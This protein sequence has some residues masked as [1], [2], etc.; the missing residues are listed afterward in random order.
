MHTLTITTLT[1][2]ELF[3][4]TQEKEDKAAFA[5]LYNRY[6]N[7]LWQ[8]TQRHQISANDAQDVLQD[9]FTY[10]WVNKGQ[11]KIKHRFSSFLFRATLNQVLKKIDR[12]KFI[13]TYAASLTNKL[14]EQGIRTEDI[15]FEKE[16]QH[17]ISTALEQMPAKMRAVFEASRFDGLSHEQ[18]AAKYRISKETVKSQ[19]KNALKIM[20]KYVNTLLFN[21]L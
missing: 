10:L 8:F 3:T 15:I 6:W 20:R 9:V 17:T 21:F 14:K 5:E 18:I 19:I 1:D 16:L 11:I 7:R 4:L 13:A 2:E 12:S